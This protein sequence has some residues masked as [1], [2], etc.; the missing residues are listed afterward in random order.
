MGVNDLGWEKVLQQKAPPFYIDATELKRLSGREPR[1][2]AKHDFSAARPTIFQELGL[3]IIPVSRSRYFVGHFNIFEPF[4]DITDPPRTVFLP[5]GI[6]SL[7]FESLSSEALALNAAVLSGIFEDFLGPGLEATVSGRMSTGTFEFDLGRPITVDRA[8]MEIDAG[9][10]SNEQLVLVE[11]KNHITPDFNIRQ[12]YFPYRRFAAL[13]KPVIPVYMVSTNGVF[14]LYQYKFADALDPGSIEL[15]AAACYVLQPSQVDAAT[16]LN[17]VRST[18]TVE[19]KPFPQADSFER[20]INLL[21]LLAD[22]M[23]IDEIRDH[24]AFVRRQANYYT[25]ALAYLGLAQCDKR[26]T[27]W[28]LTPLGEQ[29]IAKPSRDERHVELVRALATRPVFNYCLKQALTGRMPTADEIADLI[30]VAS[31]DTQSRRARTVLSWT[32]WAISLI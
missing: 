23:E 3:N 6:R 14:R 27:P 2:M 21:E 17:V 7:N 19:S 25:A 16:L 30:P 29:I 31:Y 4:P 20:V 5:Y 10:E 8:Q 32:R 11:A 12:L 1:L 24:Y 13:G 22:P 15:V 28:H 26:G 18:P 9:F